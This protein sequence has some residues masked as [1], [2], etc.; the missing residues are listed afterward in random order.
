MG[1]AEVRD[2]MMVIVGVGIPRPTGNSITPFRIDTSFAS[3]SLM[4]LIVCK[5]GVNSQ[6]VEEISIMSNG[7]IVMIS[8]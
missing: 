2:S 4:I 3:L 8:L 1:F 6:I 7:V 5:I